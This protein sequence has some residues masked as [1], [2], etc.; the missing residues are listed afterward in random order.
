M[1]E[2]ASASDV[3][4]IERFADA[5]AKMLAEIHKIVIGQDDVIELLLG[6]VLARGHCLL[7]GV[8]GLARQA[9][10]RIPPG[11]GGGRGAGCR[12]G[13]GVNLPAPASGRR[14]GRRKLEL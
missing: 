12:R 7:V 2:G 11:S 1:S 10:L 13:S 8:P 9:G 3:Q 6:A 4:V 14:S 5:K